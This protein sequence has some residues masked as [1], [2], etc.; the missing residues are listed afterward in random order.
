LLETPVAT[1]EARDD[2][3][4]AFPARHFGVDQGLHLVAPF[5]SLVGA[6]DRAQIVER[7]QDFAETLKVAVKRRR[8]LVL[9][10]CWQ[11]ETQ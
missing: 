11:N 5:C 10:A 3:A 1:I 6:A 4:A 8:C 2:L 9:R 7:A